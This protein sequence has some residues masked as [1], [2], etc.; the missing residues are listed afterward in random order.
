MGR[1][2]EDLVLQS[3]VPQFSGKGPI[4]MVKNTFIDEAPI[5]PSLERSQSA[6]AYLND[7]VTDVDFAASILDSKPT[8]D[9]LREELDTSCD[10]SDVPDSPCSTD[11]SECLGQK[12]P[13]SSFPPMVGFPFPVITQQQA[14]MF[15]HD[16]CPEAI[17]TQAFLLAL[18]TRFFTRMQVHR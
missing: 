18:R 12:T 11:G 2:L 4:L 6:P 14:A 5:H 15:H 8:F 10:D 17:S 7:L 9:G 16:L 13:T 3:K 1:V